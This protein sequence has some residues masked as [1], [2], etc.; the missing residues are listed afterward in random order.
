M[1]NEQEQT[2]EAEKV[3]SILGWLRCL[4]LHSP[5]MKRAFRLLALAL[6]MA[7]A[8]AW[9]AF[10]GNRGWTRTSVAVKTID[11]VT[12]IVAI[13]YHKQFAPGLDFLGRALLGAGLLAGI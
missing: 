7:A 9:L 3:L 8:F 6:A 1:P 12:G 13:E 4:L 11:E 10:G 2:E 5:S